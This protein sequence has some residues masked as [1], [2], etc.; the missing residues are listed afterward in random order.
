MAAQ[1]KPNRKQQRPAARPQ[2]R[3]AAAPRRTGSPTGKRPFLTPNAS[4][5]RQ[6]VE[7]RSAVFV[8]FLRGLPKAMP[9]L[10]VLGLLAGALVVQGVAGAVCALLVALL[11]AWLFFLA[12]P[13]L[14]AMGKAVR[15]LTI[16]VI[17]AFAVSRVV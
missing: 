5:F 1:R 8:L 15:L 17:I 2:A 10:L 4:P 7:R 11:L 12:W 6:A 3:G 13:A 14:P 16:G 9:G